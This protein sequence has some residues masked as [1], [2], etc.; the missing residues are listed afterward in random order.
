MREGRRWS[1]WGAAVG[2]TVLILFTLSG[3]G[4]SGPGVSAESTTPG[5]ST[6]VAASP[7]ASVEVACQEPFTNLVPVEG[8]K[9]LPGT[10]VRV[11]LEGF[12]P[13]V[14]VTLSMS[15][16]GEASP[17]TTIGGTATDQ[18]GAG[19]VQGVIPADTP[20][21][22]ASIWALTGA[23]CGSESQIVVVGSFEQISIDDDTVE[24]GQL[25]TITAGGFAPDDGVGLYLDGDPRDATNTTG[26]LG[27][28]E[29]DDRGSVVV[30]ARIPDDISPG[31][32]Y[33]LLSGSSFDG[34]ADLGL[35]VQITVG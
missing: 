32:H 13:N 5:P 6:S 29:A 16:V 34:I 9:V 33:L 10:P 30:R 4:L 17:G 31:A 25:V 11:R 24:P 3:C 21:G 28:A 26:P 12:P 1:G 8:D 23:G 35:V 14:A 18:Q 22:D 15:P 27:G 2:S 20:Y 7:L 19:F